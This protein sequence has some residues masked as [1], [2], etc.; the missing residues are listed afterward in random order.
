MTKTPNLHA[1]KLEAAT[2]KLKEYI[3]DLVT[4]E[5]IL[6]RLTKEGGT[7]TPPITITLYVCD[8]PPLTTSKVLQ[9]RPLEVC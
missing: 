9:S 8:H 3:K 5:Q 7:N 1:F 2:D 4:N 6:L